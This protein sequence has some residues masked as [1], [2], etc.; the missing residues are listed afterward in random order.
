MVGT[1]P[2]DPKGFEWLERTDPD[3]FASMSD[4]ALTRVRGVRYYYDLKVGETVYSIG[5]PVPT[6]KGLATAHLNWSFS[7]GIITALRD[8]TRLGK[9]EADVIQTNALITDGNSG[10]ALFDEYGN[11]IGITQ[12]AFS[13]ETPG[14]NI[15]LPAD[16]LWIL[17]GN[18]RRYLTSYQCKQ[19]KSDFKQAGPFDPHVNEWIDSCKVAEHW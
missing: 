14:F 6:Q 9:V 3:N 12:G 13:E 18:V 16:L 8:D 19:L 1:W 15:A 11:L 4:L 2:Q 7:D 10:G 17:Y 5:N